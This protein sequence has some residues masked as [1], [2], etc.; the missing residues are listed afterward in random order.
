MHL[1]VVISGK[2]EAGDGAVL[3]V[4]ILDHLV[5]PL[6]AVGLASALH[7]IPDVDGELR[8]LIIEV[9]HSL[10]GHILDL[11]LHNNLLGRG[12]WRQW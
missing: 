11:M 1:P 12:V 10:D 8:S 9:G 6:A 2:H 4:E 5:A 3:L 7:D